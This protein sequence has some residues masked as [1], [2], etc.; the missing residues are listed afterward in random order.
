MDQKLTKAQLQAK[1]ENAQQRITELEILLD[2]AKGT[3]ERALSSGESNE[4]T[5]SEERFKTNAEKAL[6]ESE[7]RYRLIADN[8][9]DVI[10]VLD[11][12]SGRFTYVSPSVEKLR[13]YTPEE[14]M[15]QPVSEAL[16][17]ESLKVVSD[18][19]QTDLPAF[20]TKGSGTASFINEVD[21]PHKNGS[22]VHTE[23]TT[24]YLFNERGNVEIVGVSRNIN[25]RKQAEKELERSELLL[26]EM[27]RIAKIG[28]WELDVATMKQRWTDETYV[29]HDRER[30]VY[31]P[32]ST[33]EISRFEP[34]SKERIEKAF[35]EALVE[36][37]PYDIE[38]EM[39]TVKG[40][41]KWVRAVCSPLLVDGKVTKLTGTVQDITKRKQVEEKLRENERRLREAQRIANIG[42]WEWDLRT[43]E[44]RWS[45]ENYAIHGFSPDALALTPEAL[46]KLVHPD[47]LE[48]VNAA[49][50]QAVSE[51]GS[52][53]IEYRVFRPDGT[54]RVIHAMG[55]VTEFDAEGK[56]SLMLG[57]NQDVT[58]RRRL[59]D[60]L[61]ESE[62]K[63]TLLFE[64]S[65]VPTVLLK[66]PEVTI[67]NVNEACEKLTGF[68]REEMI[69]KTSTELG[70][71]RKEER[72]KVISEFE[73]RGELALNEIALMTK[74]GERRV[75]VVNTMPVRIGGEKFAITTM[76]DVTERKHAE[77]ELQENRRV[78]Q[79][80]VEYA[81]AAIAMFDLEMRY[82]AAS[83]RYIADY[84]LPHREITG[85]SHYEIFPEIPERWKEI[86]RRCLAGGVESA[87]AD[88]FPRADGRLDWVRWEMRPWFKDDAT[89]GGIILFSEVITVRVE[90]EEKLKSLAERLDLATRS[91]HM[92]IWDWDIQKNEIIWDDQMYALYGLEPG[93]FGGAYQVWLQGVHPDD[94]EASNAVSAAA[95]RGERDYNTE[96]RVRWP[97]GSV[98]WLKAN[99]E[100]FRD[101]H[102]VP[103][104]MVGVNYDITERKSDD[105][106]LRQRTEELEQLLDLLPEAVWIADDPECKFIRGNRFANELLR[107]PANANV[108]QSS[109]SPDV[110]LR[111]FS[112]GRELGPDELPMQMAVRSGQPQLD[113]E[114]RID[115][116]D[117][118]TRH[119]LGGAIPLYD[120]QGK[121]RGAVA[122]F[123]DYTERK[124]AEERFSKAFK[125]NPVGM[126]IIDLENGSILDV[127]DAYLSIFG[128][129]REEVIGKTSVDAGL[130][131]YPGE[132][133]GFLSVL[134]EKGKLSPT[135]VDFRKRNGDTGHLIIS[136]ETIELGEKPYALVSSHDITE[137]KHME[138]ELRRSNAELEQFAYVASH[139]LQEPLRAVAGMVQLLQKRYQGQLDERADEYIHHAVE[140]SSR[141][142]SLINDLLMYS[143]VERR[144]HSIESVQSE[145]C[146]TAALNNLDVSI[147]ET[148]ARVT[149]DALPT[150]EADAT[151]LTQLFQNLIGNGIK[152]RGEKDPHIHISAAKVENAWQFSVRDNGIGI[153]RQYFERIFLIFQR[154]HTRREYAG[155]GIGLALCKKIVERHGGKIWVESSLGEGSTFYFTLP[156]RSTTP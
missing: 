54:M 57:T 23:V 66:L 32:N 2:D 20:M 38:V 95:V 76:Q 39:T 112:Q 121:T 64:K 79:L 153:E 1:L 5:Q 7:M 49:I 24:T 143:R 59:E 122:A 133:L 30:G 10:W 61:R 6:R 33:E 104:R 151:Q 101:E 130:T 139:D 25:D 82:I 126:N 4:Q 9:A 3:R 78:L 90:A 113:F 41:R 21:Q 34:G 35:E 155:T 77:R 12:T 131:I 83:Q 119:L 92:G 117:K 142:Q 152:F 124:H 89:I 107:V 75:V 146:L 128:V 73:R 94:R 19:M 116:P 71:A 148:R 138:D 123:I 26:R 44:T 127:N 36:G 72:T 136:A 42:N 135:E 150:V 63:Y 48:K 31:D 27:G 145:E 47:D 98:R 22:I 137:R 120:A 144:N 55:E 110:T 156:T 103:L 51:G 16:T 29:I 45:S 65:T 149:A 81:P 46:V 134:K 140:A 93:D 53:E 40:N 17:P 18:S 105:E 14:V 58:E 109:E 43:G 28:G 85:H 60:D 97:D 13:G 86:H 67:A 100:V 74:S 69:G 115:R 141:M 114:L 37:K 50:S 11:P 8:S 147:H 15:A 84:Q 108:S 118:I 106:I 52:V 129:T 102:G 68:K 87:E 56:P 88:P 70:L 96:F 91:A 154:L 80:F 132:R 62:Q 111:Q 99:G 125:S